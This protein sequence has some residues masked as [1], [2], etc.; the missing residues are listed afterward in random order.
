MVWKLSFIQPLKRIKY[1]IC[2]KVAGT[3]GYQLKP[4]NKYFLS[5]A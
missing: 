2:R 5:S 3:G 4:K 1:I